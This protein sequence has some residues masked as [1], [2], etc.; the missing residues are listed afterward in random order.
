M[1]Q[2]VSLNSEE[3]VFL[4]LLVFPLRRRHLESLS[5]FYN[6][7]FN[8]HLTRL[9]FIFSLNTQNVQ[10]SLNPCFNDTS[11]P[12]TMFSLNEK[13]GT[14]FFPPKHAWWKS[15]I[16]LRNSRTKPHANRVWTTVC[17]VFFLQA[18]YYRFL[19]AVPW[20]NIIL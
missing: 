17:F 7:F 16:W 20:N 5:S 12:S 4:H 8:L 9:T 11:V 6:E 14:N 13:S 1:N 3:G 19:L 10:V 15:A 2:N 18:Q